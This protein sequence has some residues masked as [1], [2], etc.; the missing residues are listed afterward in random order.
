MV[1][2]NR[3]GIQSLR[4]KGWSWLKIARRFDVATPAVVNK[5]KGNGRD[6]A[7]RSDA[8]RTSFRCIV[9]NVILSGRRKGITRLCAECLSTNQKLLL[10]KRDKELVQLANTLGHIPSAR[11][12]AGSL[13]CKKSQASMSIRRVY[14]PCPA[15]YMSQSNKRRP[16]P[17]GDKDAQHV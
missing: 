9:C 15:E 1:E 8:G 17:A 7:R 11:E 13:D 5:A 16:L 3:E 4:N 2:Y 14:G 12:A 6:I 10:L